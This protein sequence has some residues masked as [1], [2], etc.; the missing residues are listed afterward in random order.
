MSAQK[1]DQASILVSGGA[2]FVG[3]NLVKH[4]LA[5]GAAR[6]HIVD[7]LLSSERANIPADLRVT[8]SEASFT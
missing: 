6:V 7:N 8:F 4:L 3:S 2:G 1:F 5:A